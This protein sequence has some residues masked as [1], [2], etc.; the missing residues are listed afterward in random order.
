MAAMRESVSFLTDHTAKIATSQCTSQSYCS[1]DPN[2]DFCIRRGLTHY[3]I[4]H[5][6]F[7]W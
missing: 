6:P 2:F 3:Y 5:E 4:V 1:K 7:S